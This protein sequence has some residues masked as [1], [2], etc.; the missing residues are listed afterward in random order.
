M[1]SFAAMFAALTF[2][3]GT[4]VSNRNLGPKFACQ[5]ACFAGCVPKLRWK[6][7]GVLSNDGESLTKAA[8]SSELLE[9]DPD[10]A[11]R[12]ARSHA[13]GFIGDGI[14]VL[15]GEGLKQADENYGALA[16]RALHAYLFASL[17]VPFE[18]SLLHKEIFADVPAG[19]LD[20]VAVPFLFLPMH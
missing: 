20:P 3:T 18:S 8:A 6:N 2:R 9:S 7:L 14:I 4:A 16:K 17:L 12:V 11:P 13:D 19:N 15:G 10:Q 1:L 5:L